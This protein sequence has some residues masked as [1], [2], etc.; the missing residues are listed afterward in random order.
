MARE[1]QMRGVEH[2][3]EVDGAIAE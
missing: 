1:S 2:S 3:K